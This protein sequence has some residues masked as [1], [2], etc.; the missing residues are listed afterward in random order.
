M[1]LFKEWLVENGKTYPTIYN[2]EIEHLG[3]FCQYCRH[4]VGDDGNP[5]EPILYPQGLNGPSLEKYISKFGYNRLYPVVCNNC[6]KY[7]KKNP[8]LRRSG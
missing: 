3:K 4:E 2:K 1:G 8:R 7:A 5:N 6:Y